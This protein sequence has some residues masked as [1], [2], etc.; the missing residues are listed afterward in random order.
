MT[1]YA[2]EY[3]ELIRKYPLK[4]KIRNVLRDGVIYILSKFKYNKNN[5][6]AI[7]IICYHHVFDDEL[8]DFKRNINIYLTHIP[9]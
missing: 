1:K 6:A 9:L 5:K 7:R 3:K 8:N 2:K 4:I